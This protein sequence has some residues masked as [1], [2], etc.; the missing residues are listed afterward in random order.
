MTSKILYQ[1]D[2]LSLLQ[3]DDWYTYAHMSRTEPAEDGS[4]QLVAVLV[5]TFSEWSDKVDKILGR[6]ECCL[7]HNDGI[8]LTS[9][10]GGVDKG[11]TPI[12][13]AIHE[14]YEEAGFEN[15]QEEDLVPLGTC[16]PSKQSDTL[17]H[18]FAF[19]ATYKDR[20]E[21]SIGDGT[22]GEEGAYCGWISLEEAITCKCPLVPTMYMRLT[23][24]VS[25]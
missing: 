17:C 3:A 19:D 25:L 24:N 1:D 5:Y 7:P 13:S 22:L 23:N 9:I 4:S 12:E 14:L 8:E 11:S 16:R 15:V 2:N 10:T 20:R 21:D 6:F 18:L